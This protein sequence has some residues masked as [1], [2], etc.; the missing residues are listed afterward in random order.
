M[1]Q[2]SQKILEKL[3]LEKQAGKSYSEIRAELK[4]SGMNQSEINSL[5]R[6]VDEKVLEKVVMENIPDRARQLYRAGLALALTGL[7]VTIIFNMGLILKY[8]PPIAVYSPF[9]AGIL[10]MFYGRMLQRREM[11]KKNKGSGAIRKKRPYK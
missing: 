9:I 2:E 8:F 7:L 11:G 4:D 1:E 6:Q 10:L 3:V 5:I